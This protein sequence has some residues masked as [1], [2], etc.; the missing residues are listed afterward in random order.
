MAPKPKNQVNKWD[1]QL[2][3]LAQTSAVAEESALGGGAFVSTKG[4]RLSFGGAPVPGD[5]MN[6]V[7]LDSVLENHYYDVA[8]DPDNPASPVCFAFGRDEKTI[9]PHDG[10]PEPQHTQCKGC[11][12]NE[13]GTD[14]RGKGKACANVRRLALIPESGLEDIE[15]ADVAYLKVPVMSV[16]NWAG[17]VTQLATTLKRPP[18]AVVTEVSVVPDDK[19]QFRVQ[20]KF[21]REITD[22]Q[23]LGELIA[24]NEVV[25]GQIGFPYQ[26]VESEEVKKPQRGTKKAEPAK[27]PTTAKG[28]QSAGNTPAKTNN[29]FSGRR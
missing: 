27:K 25:Q 4:G 26:A 21:V 10:A 28:R 13:F 29:K 5:K 12:L 14:E 1:A 16:K 9:C 8:F 3:A 6:V 18:F 11:P 24:K 2:A 7:V 19:S 23:E 22:S 15:G 17:Y 20:F